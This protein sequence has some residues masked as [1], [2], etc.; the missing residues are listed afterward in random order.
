MAAACG[1]QPSRCGVRLT[2]P[3]G[4]HQPEAVPHPTP[5]RN[6]PMGIRWWV[7]ATRGARRSSA[8]P[9]RPGVQL[10]GEAGQVSLP[11][12]HLEVVSHKAEP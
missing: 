11:P 10:P 12:P 5:S 1:A 9:P 3:G 8:P 6:T 4:T 7:W 2:A